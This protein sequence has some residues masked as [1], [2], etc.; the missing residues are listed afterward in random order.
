VL[1]AARRSAVLAATETQLQVFSLVIAA[2]EPV[3]ARFRG[4]KLPGMLA[5]AATMRVQ[6]SWDV[7]TITTVLALQSLSR[8]VRALTVEAAEH[9][10]AIRP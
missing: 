9:E 6:S 2:P 4:Q 8:R 1:L 3:R 7:E 5:T 10:K